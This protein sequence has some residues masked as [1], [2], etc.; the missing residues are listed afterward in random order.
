[1]L[2]SK[3][4]SRAEGYANLAKALGNTATHELVSHTVN[5]SSVNDLEMLGNLLKLEC[6]KLTKLGNKFA[7][8]TP[9]MLCDINAS[10]SVPDASEEAANWIAET[11][12][13]GKTSHRQIISH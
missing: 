13:S 3:D 2:K 8:L 11:S 10:I 1:M 9:G 7:R 4:F 12:G 6:E 5:T